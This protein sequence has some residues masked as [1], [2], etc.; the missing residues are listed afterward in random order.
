M[1]T[2]RKWRPI[3]N[4]DLEN[5]DPSKKKTKNM[6]QKFLEADLP[7]NFQDGGN[8]AWPFYSLPALFSHKRAQ[9]N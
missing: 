3:E 6:K 7:S 4:K 5:E 8:M 1:K 2:P 9:N